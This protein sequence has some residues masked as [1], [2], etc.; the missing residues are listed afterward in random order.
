MRYII[1]D[2]AKQMEVEPHVLRY[3]EEELEVEIPRNEMGHRYYRD[4]DIKLMSGVKFLKEKG[5]QL[6]AIRLLLPEMDK[7]IALDARRLLE[8]RDRLELAMNQEELRQQREEEL[9]E[10]T[11]NVV[12]LTQVRNREAAV[13]VAAEGERKPEELPEPERKLLQFKTFMNEIVREAVA[14]NNRTLTD[15]LTESIAKEMEYQMR[16]KEML[17]EERYKKLDR[18]IR[19]YQQSQ[20]QVAAA[21]E[22]GGRKESKFF[23]KHRVRI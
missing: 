11:D 12:Q 1:S 23:K 21:K 6:K 4:E 14:E 15:N 16:R 5:F 10:N 18:T 2:A 7:I 19:E 22:S 8:L 13:S 9:K 3:W 20:K 17:E